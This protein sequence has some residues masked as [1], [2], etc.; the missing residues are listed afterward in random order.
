MA[1]SYKCLQCNESYDDPLLAEMCCMETYEL[2]E[3]FERNGV[4]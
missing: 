1:K 4:Y 3:A 2:F